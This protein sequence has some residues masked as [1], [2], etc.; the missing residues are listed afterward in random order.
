MPGGGPQF[1][2]FLDEKIFPFAQYIF[3]RHAKAAFDKETQR[4]L[5]CWSQIQQGAAAKTLEVPQELFQTIRKA[6][7]LAR[8]GRPRG[9]KRSSRR[10]AWRSRTS[11]ITPNGPSHF[12][13]RTHAGSDPD[14]QLTQE[15]HPIAADPELAAATDDFAG[16]AVPR[17]SR[18]PTGLPVSISTLP[19]ST[20]PSS[21][22]K[23]SVCRSPATFPVFHN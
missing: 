21:M 4:R 18:I 9:C 20:A 13:A 17:G 8:F 22:V 7:G 3:R 11:A 23:R 1:V 10:R 19:R 6:V 14:S 16:A 5:P 12:A 2:F 15:A